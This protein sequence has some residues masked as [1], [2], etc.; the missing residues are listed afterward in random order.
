MPE[1]T[2]GIFT[3]VN[4]MVKVDNGGIRIM[5]NDQ[6]LLTGDT[7]KLK[8]KEDENVYNDI[9]GCTTFNM[10]VYFA[11]VWMFVDKCAYAMISNFALCTPV[12]DCITC[13]T[14]SEVPFC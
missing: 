12:T 14:P 9:D 11:I 13:D 8:I 6:Q 1:D 7:L 4:D 2:M 3:Y 5:K 10:R